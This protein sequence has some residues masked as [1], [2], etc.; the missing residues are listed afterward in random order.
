MTPISQAELSDSEIRVAWLLPSMKGGYYWQPLLREFNKLFP[1]TLIFTSE[2]PGYIAKHEGTFEVKVLSGVRFFTLK[3]SVTGADMTFGLA[4]PAPFWELIKFRPH[5]L[6]TSVFGMWTLYGLLYKVFTR[7]PVILFWDGISDAVA[8][9]NSRLRLKV[10]KM[11]ARFVDGVVCNSGE[12]IEYLRNVIAI[13]KSKL[14]HQPFY[15]PEVAALS[16]LEKNASASRASP[17]P[18]FLFVG[19][20]IKRK[21]WRYLLE[22]SSLLVKKGV[23]TF[24]LVVVGEGAERRLLESSVSSMGLQQVVNV[25]GAVP[26][27]RLGAFFEVADVF[28]LPTLED[29]WGV[30]VSEAMAFGKPVLCSKYAG[31]KELVRDG[32]NGF[33]FDPYNAA[34]LAGYM[35]RFIRQ[36]ELIARFGQRSRQIIAP[37]TPANA[38]KT[39]GARIEKLLDFTVA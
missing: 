24:S 21:G 7:S 13:P 17:R 2:W 33:V 23:G 4:S 38:A 35:E 29:T 16:S 8:Y 10:R 3:R 31:A 25:V 36:P 15:V 37:Y 19:Q 28:I 22:A 34:E 1:N 5:V 39:L 11:M 32:I 9:R 26:Y 12:G 14:L 6:F 30:V 18:I 20:V 27:Q